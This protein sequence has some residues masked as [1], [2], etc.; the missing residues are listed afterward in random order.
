MFLM[1]LS[2][3]LAISLPMLILY[4]VFR[5]ERNKWRFRVSHLLA[6]MLVVSLFFGFAYWIT[7]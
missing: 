2:V 1:L 6:A 3:S 7:H 5:L 4:L